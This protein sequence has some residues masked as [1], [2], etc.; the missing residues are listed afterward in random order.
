MISICIL[1]IDT[2]FLCIYLFQ[3]F[4]VLWFE[5]KHS[6]THIF[7][8][9]IWD[10]TLL[11]T[12]HIMTGSFMGRGNQN[13]QLDKVLYCKLSTSGKELPTFLHKVWGFNRQ[14]QR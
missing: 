5:I 12:G 13:K 6:G 1:Q 4:K 7:D 2:A 10:F 9:F 3:L 11:S 8:L 14:A